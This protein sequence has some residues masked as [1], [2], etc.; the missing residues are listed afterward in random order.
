MQ[1]STGLVWGLILA[2]VLLGGGYYLWST[3]QSASDTPSPNSESG[4]SGTSL[5]GSGAGND[6][7]L[8][9]DGDVDEFASGSLDV[10]VNT[11][12][13]TATVSYDGNTFT[14]KTV[15]IRKGG[16]VTWTNDSDSNMWVASAQHPSHSVYAGT[17]RQQHC[18]D[19]SNT[20][21]DQCAGSAGNYSFTFEKE[22]TWNYHDHIN[23]SVFGTVIVE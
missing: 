15:T 1:N 16:T 12:P 13:M 3:S 21:F 2:V 10:G 19:A 6:T 17:T 7:D 14:P 22:G 11:A 9:G 18:P 20:A 4:A 23:A 8:D 5:A